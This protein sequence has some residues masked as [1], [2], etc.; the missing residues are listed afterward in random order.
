MQGWLLQHLLHLQVLYH[1]ASWE[2][3]R[4]RYSSGMITQGSS[5]TGYVNPIM[6]TLIG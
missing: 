6:E 1:C 3:Q 4:A 5:L 2:I